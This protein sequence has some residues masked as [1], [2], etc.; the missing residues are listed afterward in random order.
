[1]RVTT[2]VFHKG[3]SINVELTGASS[4]NSQHCNKQVVLTL[5]GGKGSKGGM[6]EKGE[7]DGQVKRGM[8]MRRRK[9]ENKTR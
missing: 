7:R 1:M 2:L 8:N 4:Q 5:Y 3:R 9:K 6:R